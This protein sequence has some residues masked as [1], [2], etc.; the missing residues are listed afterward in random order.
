[1]STEPTP[2]TPPG[3]PQE[4]GQ[5]ERP[6]PSRWQGRSEL[7]VCG[8]LLVVGVLVLTDAFT[9]DTVASV[10]GPVGPRTVPL[11]VGVAL[12]VVALVLAVD[13]LRGGRGDTEGAGGPDG[14][15]ETEGAEGAAETKRAGAEGAPVKDEPGDWRT[16]ALLVGVFLAFAALIEPIG[17]PL[18]GALLFWGSAF[19]LGSRTH[20]FTRDPLIAAGISLGTY[21]LFHTLLGVPLPGGP[22]M[23][24][25]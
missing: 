22:L 18:A 16:V 8:L 1:M 10:R 11:V 21:V 12:L 17:F 19:T 4:S 13:V 20:T 25:L 5:P 24:V 6:R 7:G 15:E 23:G 2:G 3:S 9:M 14:P